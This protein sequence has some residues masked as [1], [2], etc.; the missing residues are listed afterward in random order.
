MPQA[1]RLAKALVFMKF[2]VMLEFIILGFMLCARSTVLG[3]VCGV[4]F[5]KLD[6][7][8]DIEVVKQGTAVMV[9]LFPNMI[10]TMLMVVLLIAGAFKYNVLLLTAVMIVLETIVTIALF[11]WVKRLARE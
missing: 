4:K 7:E 11:N 2:C 9:Y 10:F 5:M 3:M 1:K 8:N 6:W